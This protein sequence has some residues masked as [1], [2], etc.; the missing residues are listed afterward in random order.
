MK[1]GGGT[2]VSSFTTVEVKDI[3]ITLYAFVTVSSNSHI[4]ICNS[5]EQSKKKET[6][7]VKK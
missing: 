3:K 7:I 4:L 2:D 6:N 1:G 5:P